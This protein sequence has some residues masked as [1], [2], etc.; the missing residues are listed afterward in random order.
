MMTLTL[1]F[2]VLLMAFFL[3]WIVTQTIN[4][5]P[6]QAAATPEDAHS[7]LPAFLTTPRVGLIV[8]LAAITSLFALT[9]SAYNGRMMLAEDWVPL[10][11]P[12]IL[13]FNTAALVF[14][15]LA[16][17]WSW[18]SAERA[19]PA[20]VRLGLTAAGVGTLVFI[21]GQAV[22]WWQ[23]RIGGHGL[24]ENP[25]NAFFYLVTAL[26]VVHLIGGL[27]A[28]SRAMYRIYFG[29]KRGTVAAGVGLCTIYWHYLLAV[30]LVLFGLILST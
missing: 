6:W 10:E 3:G 8:V 18:R 27:V 23:L 11:A 13:W 30:W 9:I 19:E 25:A 17:H 2:I 22:A 29:S 28:W 7:R 21:T 4:V 20:R 1:V 26:H 24:T 12:T 15:S 14:C 16:M 5:Q